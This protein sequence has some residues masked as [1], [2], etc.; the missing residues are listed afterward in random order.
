MRFENELCFK[1]LMSIAKSNRELGVFFICN[2][3]RI[4]FKEEKK[5]PYTPYLKHNKE[6]S[7]VFTFSMRLSEKPGGGDTPDSCHYRHKAVR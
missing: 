5:K 1:Q 2:H 7:G 3:L 4:I 6:L